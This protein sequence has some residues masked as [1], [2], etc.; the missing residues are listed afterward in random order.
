MAISS[1]GIAA[2]MEAVDYNVAMRRLV[3]LAAA[4]CLVILFNGFR[5]TGCG[6]VI[7][8]LMTA[9]AAL[10]GGGLLGFLFGVPHTRESASATSGGQSK[11][12]TEDQSASNSL[13]ETYRPSTSLEQIS[14]WLT[15]ILVGV[16]LVDF[17]GIL[18][19]VVAA[20]DYIAPGLTGVVSR[21]GARTFAL[22]I[23]VYFSVSGFVFGFLWARL[24]LPRWFA[25]ADRVKRLLSRFEVQQQAD[26]KALLLSHGLLTPKQDV[27]SASDSEIA[28]AVK[29]ASGAVRTQMFSQAATASEDYGASD[30]QAKLKGAIALFKSLAAADSDELDHRNYSELSYALRR[31][32]PPDLDGAEKAIT[33]AIQIRDKLRLN[34]WRY[35]E[36]RRA[37]YRIEQDPQFSQNKPSDPGFVARVLPDLKAAFLEANRSKRDWFAKEGEGVVQRWMNLNNVDLSAL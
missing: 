8:G 1:T 9:G 20:G 35:Y 18:A 25:E 11:T 22:A 12:A 6:A 16:G 37:R 27:P 19:K 3:Y 7:V 29:E 21:E 28:Q 5:S 10:L 23:L 13:S 33:K 36:F 31:Q 17:R 26:A 15:K 24:Y 2:Q 34:G 4:G 14:D 32:K 30:H